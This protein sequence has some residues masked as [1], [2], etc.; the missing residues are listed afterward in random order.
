MRLATPIKIQELQQK[1]HLKAKEEPEFRFYS[2]YDKVYRADILAHAWALC[3]ANG[4]A[5]GVDG[6]TFEDIE[7][8]GVER[9]L[10]EIAQELRNQ[11]YQ[12]SAVRRV[13]IPKKTGGECT[14]ADRVFTFHFRNDTPPKGGK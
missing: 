13:M 7:A 9:F 4:G 11:A 6:Q 1:L 12:P 2:L 5:P 3:R 10:G 8:Y 14:T